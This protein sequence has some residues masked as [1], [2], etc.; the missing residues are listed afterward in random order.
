MIKVVMDCFGGDGSPR[1]NAD[2]AIAALGKNADL[3]MILSGDEAQ[4]KEALSGK[5]YP[6]ERLEILH[7][8][9][10]IG[11]DEKPTEAIRAKRDS[12][13]MA[14][15]E[16]LRTDE[17]VAGMVSVGSTGA[18]IAATTLR[19]GRLPG[20]MRPAFCPILPTMT[21]GIVGICDSGAVVDCSPEMLKQFAIM[22]S[23]YL[24]SA[25]GIESPRAALLNI[26]TES[27]KGD[28][29]RKETYPLL[30]QL[31]GVNFVGNME[32]RDLLTGKYDLIV[33]DGF[34]G[35]VL[36]KTTEGACLEMLKM[37]K[38]NIYSSWKYKLG[39]LL[40]KKMFSQI[41]EFMN[42]QNY[43]GSVILGARKTVVK[44]H[45]SSDA[46]AIEVC[47][48][49]VCRAE[50]ARMNEKISEALSGHTAY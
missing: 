24:Q 41:K 15:T 16:L 23:V 25:F 50:N 40:Q 13:M 38:K 45:G 43:G 9:T 17:T 37:L 28:K 33:C 21:G 35:N 49:Q 32:S 8:P 20:V 22:G 5:K 19:V 47:I 30:E 10:V 48:D 36:I 18:L 11:C 39:A 46:R 26:G 3:Y 29:L 7:A 31:E 44:G 12:S 2:G 42:Y 1:A 14:A 27:E 34:S 4:I 6:A